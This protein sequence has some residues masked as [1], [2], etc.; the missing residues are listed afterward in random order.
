M[1]K[2]LTFRVILGQFAITR[3]FDIFLSPKEGSIDKNKFGIYFILYSTFETFNR[4]KVM[5]REKLERLLLHRKNIIPVVIP[6]MFV[7]LQDM[8]SINIKTI[9]IRLLNFIESELK[10]IH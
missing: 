8:D 4:K 5:N 10:K 9:Q 3:F 2:A 1:S 7:E 6:I